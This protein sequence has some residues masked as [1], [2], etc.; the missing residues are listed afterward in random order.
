M[1]HATEQED[2]K[3]VP[4]IHALCTLPSIACDT[5]LNLSIK[6]TAKVETGWMVDARAVSWCCVL[7]AVGNE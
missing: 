2:I 3:S 4:P 1:G 5:A 6:L 7:S